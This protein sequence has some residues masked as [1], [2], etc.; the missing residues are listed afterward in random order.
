M[1]CAWLDSGQ[2]LTSNRTVFDRPE[3]GIAAPAAEVFAIENAFEI[4]FG[5]AIIEQRSLTEVW[6]A[7]GVDRTERAAS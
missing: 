7:L 2:W 6:E 4:L 5:R 1:C 3:L